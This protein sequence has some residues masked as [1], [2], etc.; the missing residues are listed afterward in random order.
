VTNYSGMAVKIVYIPMSQI[1]SKLL[2]QQ[3]H[4]RCKQ[5]GQ[6]DNSETGTSAIK[7]TEYNQPD[8]K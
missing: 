5:W 8:P 2:N 4:I 7:L 3:Q 6:I 1:S